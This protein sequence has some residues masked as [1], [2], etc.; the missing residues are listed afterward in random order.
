MSAGPNML[1]PGLSLAQ[2]FAPTA[3]QTR[4]NGLLQ[5]MVVLRNLTEPQVTPAMS[6]C[7]DHPFPKYAQQKFLIQLG[8]AGQ[9]HKHLLTNTSH[10][11]I[12]LAGYLQL[13]RAHERRGTFL[14]YC[15]AVKQDKSSGG[16][17]DT[18]K[19]RSDPQRVR[20]SSGE[21]PIGAAR[22]KQSDTVTLPTPPPSPPDDEMTMTKFGRPN[23]ANFHHF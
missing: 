8:A 1:G 2:Y 12:A 5:E 19:T 16:S 17:V 20:M 4:C 15:D 23:L 22:G 3:C 7:F 9:V 18:T 11:Y 14:F 6:L 13:W 21:R 10:F